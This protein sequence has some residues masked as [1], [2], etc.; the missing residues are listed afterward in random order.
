MSFDESDSGLS[1]TYDEGNEAVVVSAVDVVDGGVEG[2]GEG[3][4]PE[5]EVSRDG[6]VV[7]ICPK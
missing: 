3:L 1:D 7:M 6:G 4:V 2:A 5:E